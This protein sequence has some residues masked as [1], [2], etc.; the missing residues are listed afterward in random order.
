MMQCPTF[1]DAPETKFASFIHFVT[2][3]FREGHEIYGSK[4]ITVW[5]LNVSESSSQVISEACSDLQEQRIRVHCDTAGS[6]AKG[7][8]EHKET[9]TGHSIKTLVARGHI[10]FLPAS[11]A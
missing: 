9:D 7:A 3:T 6:K 8:F 1:C 5:A 10:C 2:E 4:A 11:I